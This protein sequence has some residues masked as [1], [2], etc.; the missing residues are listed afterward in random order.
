MKTPEFQKYFTQSNTISPTNKEGEKSARVHLNTWVMLG[1]PHNS[2]F[3]AKKDYESAAQA[4]TKLGN[5][6]L[7][8]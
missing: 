1:N 6:K 5:A 3:F 8:V 7:K 2:Y 4:S